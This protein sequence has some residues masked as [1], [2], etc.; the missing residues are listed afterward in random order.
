MCIRL[1]SAHLVV[2]SSLSAPPLHLI[3]TRR[4]IINVMKR[5]ES[6]PV[7][8]GAERKLIDRKH[9]ITKTILDNA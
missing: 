5:L 2:Y 3:D 7:A 6:A 1:R 9:Q 8:C 4:S